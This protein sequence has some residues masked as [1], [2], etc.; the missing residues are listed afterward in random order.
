LIVSLALCVFLVFIIRILHTNPQFLR[1]PVRGVAWTLRQLLMCLAD[2][3]LVLS[4]ETVINGLLR[5]RNFLLNGVLLCCCRS[6]LPLS[7]SL[8]QRLMFCSKTTQRLIH[9]P[10]CI[11]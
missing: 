7:R 4:V 6:L 1:A 10:L 11:L 3:R 8:S 5:K 9:L 2:S